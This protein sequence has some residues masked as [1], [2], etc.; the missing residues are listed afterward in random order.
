MNRSIPTQF[1]KKSLLQLIFF[2]CAWLVIPFTSSAELVDK[3]VAIVNN[4]VITLSELEEEAATLYTTIARNNSSGSL[5]E[6][7]SKAKEVTL[8]NMIDQRLIG[9]RAKK[10]NISVTEEEIDAAYEKMRVSAGLDPADFINKLEISG[11][12]EQLYRKRL[13]S[14]IL[15]SKLIGFD[16]RS[17]IIISDEMILKYYNKE[18]TSKVDE[19]NYY[20]LQ[21]GFTWPTPDVSNPQKNQSEKENTLRR[22]ERVYNLAKNGQDFRTLAK[23]FSD[24][25][26]ASDGGDIGVFALDEMAPSMREAIR[27]IQSNELTEIIETSAGYQFFKVLSGEDKNVVATSSFEAV[28]DEIKEKLYEEKLKEAYAEWVKQI[29]ESAYI[30]KLSQ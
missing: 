5:L 10:Y 21:I 26:S 8:N 12:N 23:K 3:V 6:D 16:V 11:V 24:L 25:P 9:Q 29:K 1:T 13:R 20:L 4:E 28:K 27:A 17:K 7:L 30:Q 19:G 18:Y 2:F 14:Q 22:A 15:Q